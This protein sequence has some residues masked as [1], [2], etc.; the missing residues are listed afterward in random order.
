MEQ[1]RWKIKANAETRDITF[2]RMKRKKSKI[3]HEKRIEFYL[4]E[5]KSGFHINSLT[6]F[7]ELV[8]WKKERANNG[9]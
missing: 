7:V 1:K 5:A 4:L 3:E 8:N 9:I 6:K 2:S